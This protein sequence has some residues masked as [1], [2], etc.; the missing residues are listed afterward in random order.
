VPDLTTTP[1]I[2]VVVPALNEEESIPELYNRVKEVMAGLEKTFEFILIDD[3][4]TDGTF[5]VAAELAKANP[6]IVIIRHAAN[7]GK[8]IALMQGFQAARGDIAVTMD[9][10]LQD[11]PEMIGRLLAKLEEGYDLVGGARIRRQD[12]AGRRIVSKIYN[13]LISWVFKRKLEDVNCGFK[14]MRRDL[15]QKIELYGDLHRLIP[16]LAIM[17]GF[18]VAE[19]PVEHDER[20]FGTSKYRLL[21][22]RG[23]LDIISLFLVNASQVR[24][25][26]VFFEL[27]FFFW[28]VTFACFGT[29]ILLASGIWDSSRTLDI[30]STTLGGLGTW[31]AF[32][33]TVLPLFGFF[34]EVEARRLQTHRWRERL[35][36]EVVRSPDASTN[37]VLEVA[38]EG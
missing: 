3:G 13:K 12:T 10:D 28:V 24:P 25:F 33:G 29:W 32:V 17:S 7:H 5:A 2:S 9:A 14:A 36:A 11:K 1:T 37:A 23:I 30:L 19:V 8:S 31:S 27:A 15:Y 38:D 4:S 6:N 26:H 18:E 35:V 21:R 34:L 16:G 22:H 20:K